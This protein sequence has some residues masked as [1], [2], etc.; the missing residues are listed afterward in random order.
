VAEQPE[1]IEAVEGL[2]P[3]DKAVIDRIREVL[4]ENDAL[5]R[6]GLTLLHTHFD[7]DD[8][9]VLVEKVD[10]E[11][12]TITIRPEKKAELEEVADPV[13]TSWRLRPKGGVEATLQCFR[14]KGGVYHTI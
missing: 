8:D 1:R 6:F 5:D 13:A 11:L 4:E 12:R 3:E 14:N 9:E 10:S 2:G 7:L